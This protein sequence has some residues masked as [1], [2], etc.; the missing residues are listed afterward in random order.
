VQN[1][2]CLDFGF[3][4]RLLC[5]DDFRENGLSRC[6]G[7]DAGKPVFYFA[8]FVFLEEQKTGFEAEK[9]L[10]K[11]SCAVQVCAQKTGFEG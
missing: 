6:R 9:V 8:A 5:F 7:K 10:E 4:A 11:P 3:Q 1:S 2:D